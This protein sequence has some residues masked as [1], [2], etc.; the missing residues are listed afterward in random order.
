M[1][2]N[3]QKAAVVEALSVLLAETYT[4]YLKTQNYHW[5]VTGPHF[6]QLHVLFQTQYEELALANDLLAERIRALG[7]KAPGSYSVFSKLSSI[8]EE[9]GSPAAQQMLKNLVKDHE[10]LIASA[11]AVLK[12]AELA[13]D[14]PTLDMATQRM[15]IHQKTRWMLAAHLE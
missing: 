4:L 8:K 2:R 14:Q 13:G 1:T 15:D 3:D 11:E 5:N 6:S 12:V 7:E 10:T 9:T